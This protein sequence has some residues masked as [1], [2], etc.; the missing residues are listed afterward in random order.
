MGSGH[1]PPSWLLEGGFLRDIGPGWDLSGYHRPEGVLI[2][3]G[4]A[5]RSV[6]GLE[7]SIVDVAPTVLYLMDL[8][9]PSYMDGRLVEE[10]LS[11]ELL[12]FRAPRTCDSVP[13]RES[14]A[15]AALADEELVKLIR[16]FE[17]LG[18]L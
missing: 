7:A 6:Q 1:L 15:A 10:A 3:F 14:G 5:F 9:I 17:A 13:V 12:R 16:R 4:P 11:P 18:Y 2:G 8:P